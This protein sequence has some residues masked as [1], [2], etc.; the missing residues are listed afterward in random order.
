MI[1]TDEQWK[2]VKEAGPHFR[3]ARQDYVRNAPM[4]LTQMLINIYESATGKTLAN[5]DVTCAGCVLRVYQTVGK[6]YFSDLEERENL[7]K[8]KLEKEENKDERNIQEGNEKPKSR[9]TKKKKG[10]S[11]NVEEWVFKHSDS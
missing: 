11:R 4:Y 8:E 9:N 7:E 2:I 6:A 1:F 10:N 3:T 5:K